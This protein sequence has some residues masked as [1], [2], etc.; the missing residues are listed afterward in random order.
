[1]PDGTK[2]DI[3]QATTLKEHAAALSAR[4][5]VAQSRTSRGFFAT[6]FRKSAPRFRPTY[7]Y[8]ADGAAC[9]VYGTITAKKVTANLHITTSGHGYASHHHTDHGGRMLVAM[10]LSHV[11]TEFSFGPYFPD[12]TQPLDNSFELTQ[13]RLLADCLIAFIAYQY[14]LHIVPTTYVAPRSKPL[15][16]NQY[17]VTHYTRVLEQ[18]KGTPGIYFKFDLDPL[19]ITIHQRTTSFV[20]LMIRCVGVIGGVF[21]CMGYAVKITTHAVEAVSGADKT[22]GIVAAEAT[23]ISANIRKKFGSADLRLRSGSSGSRVVRQGTGWAV[24]GGSPY[25]SYAS[26]PVSTAFANS[27]PF[28]PSFPANGSAAAS[29][30]PALTPGGRPVG[31]GLGFSS[32]SFGPASPSTRP[33][34]GTPGSVGSPFPTAATAGSPYVPVAMS[35]PPTPGTANG[36]YAH[37]PPTP[38]VANGSPTGFAAQQ[39]LPPRRESGLRHGSN[40][41]LGAD[42]IAKKD[43]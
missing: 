39:G 1:M 5:A 8:K 42:V 24:E 6:L 10:N 38:N 31:Y 36:L 32:P 2:F 23:G 12:I 14:F 17:S 37:F 26:T 18:H 29:P 34:L 9:R 7:N 33:P 16:T 19:S 35:T 11:I 40:G 20:Q 21:V 30:N 13:D 41:H 27:S 4:Q 3:G 15:H 43:D 28:T 22:Q 25:G